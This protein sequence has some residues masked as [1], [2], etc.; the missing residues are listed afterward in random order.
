MRLHLS[1]GILEAISENPGLSVEFMEWDVSIEAKAAQIDASLWRFTE[2]NQTAHTNGKA[3]IY[4]SFWNGQHGLLMLME[5]AIKKLSDSCIHTLLPSNGSSFSNEGEKKQKNR[6]MCE[7]NLCE[8]RGYL[9]FLL[10]EDIQLIIQTTYNQTSRE[11]ASA[12][13][14]DSTVNRINTFPDWLR[15]MAA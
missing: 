2:Q 12:N 9:L 11:W 3:S 13:S 15:L 4:L 6:N 14:L 5:L 7:C 8:C 10:L 1:G